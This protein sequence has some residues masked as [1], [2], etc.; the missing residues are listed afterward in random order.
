MLTNVC[1]VLI[2][3]IAPLVSAAPAA[4]Q[5]EPGHTV[6]SA[7]MNWNPACC[8][9]VVTEDDKI[10]IELQKCGATVTIGGKWTGKRFPPEHFT[11]YYGA[12]D[13]YH[14]DCIPHE[15]CMLSDNP[16]IRGGYAIQFADGTGKQCKPHELLE[17]NLP[18][19]CCLRVH[20][21]KKCNETFKG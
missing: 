11:G 20:T 2:V 17:T 16:D 9:T 19:N 1:L 15:E 4:L 13:W 8:P 7:G 3:A 12:P 21:G 10:W 6:A 18:Y 5:P 14:K